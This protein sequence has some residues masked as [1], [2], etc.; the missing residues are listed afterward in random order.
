MV[1]KTSGKGGGARGGNI[2]LLLLMVHL[3]E[4]LN[5]SVL[6]VSLSL[7]VLWK[8]HLGNLYAKEHLVMKGNKLFLSFFPPF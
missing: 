5:R 3:Y 6:Q 2:G 1:W 7:A 4:K 8:H